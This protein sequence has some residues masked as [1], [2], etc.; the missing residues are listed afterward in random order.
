MI[1]N[2]LLGTLCPV[3]NGY[4]EIANNLGAVLL[5]KGCVSVCAATRNL[6]VDGEAMMYYFYGKLLQDTSVSRGQ[7]GAAFALA[8]TSYISTAGLGE[9]SWINLMATTLYGD[10]SLRQ[11]GYDSTACMDGNIWVCNRGGPPLNLSV[12]NITYS[13]PWIIEV[14][15]TSMAVAPGESSD[16]A[17]IIQPSGLSEGYYYDTLRIASNDPDEAIYKEP[18]TLRVMQGGVSEIT[19][20]DNL[21]LKLETY[22]NPF[23]KEVHIKC[24]MPLN[25][26]SLK[27]YDVSG[28]LVKSLPISNKKTSVTWDASSCPAGIYFVK[29]TVGNSKATGKLILMK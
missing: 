24:S 26:V 21:Y 2:R 6:W 1:L 16:V 7:V 22:P 3:L 8:W 12:S 25:K 13:A 18:I 11:I 29:L 4:P 5:N 28:R 19:P 17:L 15:P 9:H 27:I 20:T 10:P 14:A 23:S